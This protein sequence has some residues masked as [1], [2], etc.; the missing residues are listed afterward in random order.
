M[1]APHIILDNLSSLCQKLSDLVEVW[2]SY[3]L[4]KIILFVFWDTL[5]LY[6]IILMEKLCL[7]NVDY[8][9]LMWHWSD[10]VQCMQRISLT[11]WDVK[12]RAW[13]LILKPL[14]LEQQI[15][16]V[17]A[18]ACM[19][20]CVINRFVHWRSHGGSGGYYPPFENMGLVICSN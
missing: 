12:S 4:T 15:I 13:V 19:T 7:F 18:N 16:I 11:S 1:S 5:Q 9:W 10:A 20:S 8:R 14:L 2:R 6:R 3:R 17:S